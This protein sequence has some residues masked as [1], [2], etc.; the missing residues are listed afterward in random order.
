VDSRQ[1]GMEAGAG[2][3][4]RREGASV[5]PCGRPLTAPRGVEPPEAGVRM[6]GAIDAG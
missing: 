5:G 1:A 3:Q 6:D 2:A 4:K